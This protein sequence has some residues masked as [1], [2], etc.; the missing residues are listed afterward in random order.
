M[1]SGVLGEDT[2]DKFKNTVLFMVGINW[3]LRVGDEHY[4]LHISK[5]L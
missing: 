1:E 5:V 4:K 3:G 2:P